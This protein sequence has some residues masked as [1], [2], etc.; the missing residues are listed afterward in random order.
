MKGIV[1][2]LKEG[3]RLTY[4]HNT[5]LG[6]RDFYR[7]ICTALNLS[8]KATA[9][10]VFYEITT[11]VTELSREQ[12]RPVLIIDEAHLLH[13][14]VLDHLH[15]LG[16]YGWDSSPLLTIMLIGLPELEK[17]LSLRRNRSLSS[18]ISRRF[19]IGS[20]RSEDTGEYIR[21]RLEV[22]GCIRELFSA[23][24][25]ALIHEAAEGTL[26]DLDRLADNAIRHAAIDPQNSPA[27][28][29]SAEG[30]SRVRLCTTDHVRRDRGAPFLC[31]RIDL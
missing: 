25:I 17:L 16:N 18:R 21:A 8:P 31:R 19:R 28:R 6:R 7:Q 27:L 22:A 13:Q 30:I 2:L 24:A 4:C 3:Y 1:R 26:R 12:V 5:T 15:I 10:A 11:H 20:L 9:A 14:D 23:D 29:A